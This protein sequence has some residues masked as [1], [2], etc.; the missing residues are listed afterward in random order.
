M[1][2]MSVHIVI[3]HLLGLSGL[4]LVRHLWLKSY[5][6]EP[7]TMAI[8]SD[9]SN[10]ARKE[11]KFVLRELLLSFNVKQ[12]HQPN[13]SMD[14]EKRVTKKLFGRN[15]ILSLKARKI[16]FKAAG[17]KKHISRMLKSFSRLYSSFS[18]EVLSALLRLL[19]KASDSADLVEGLK[20]S[21]SHSASSLQTGLDDWKPVIVKLLD[22]EPEL[23]VNLFREIIDM[24]ETL[25]SGNYNI[26]KFCGIH[27]KYSTLWVFNMFLWGYIMVS[28]FTI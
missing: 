10:N 25:E 9:P 14:K 5:Y 6:W 17:P 16:F 26:G 19:L 12:T 15:K 18:P 21:F 8:P 27:T 20:N 2:V 3:C 11:I 4:L 24:I 7:Q 23:L 28:T 1:F 22:I 13:S